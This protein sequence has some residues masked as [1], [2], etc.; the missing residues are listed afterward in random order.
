M[1]RFLT[2]ATVLFVALAGTV[3]TAQKVMSPEQLDPAMKRVAAAQGAMLKAIKSEA[4]ADARTQAATLKQALM[5]AQNLWE[6]N[7]K[8]DA[9]QIGNDAIAR[10]TAV[11]EAL[12]AASP[13]MQTVM[14][15]FKQVGGTCAACHKQYR[16][17]NDD[18]TYSI[19]PGA[20]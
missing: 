7:K 1:R 20:I 9:I 5:D 14:G 19:R 13:D 11:E 15:A 16:V 18:M 3:A 8:D 10:V 12:A 2:Y 17:Q 6:M 4:Y